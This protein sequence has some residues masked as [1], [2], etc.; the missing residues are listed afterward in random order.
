MHFTKL[1]F[2]QDR[3]QKYDLTQLCKRR[4]QKLPGIITW[5]N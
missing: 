2:V 4:L 1:T 3:L 5:S